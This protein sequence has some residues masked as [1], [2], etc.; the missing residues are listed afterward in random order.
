VQSGY[1]L[2]VRV[3]GLEDP[4]KQGIQKLVDISQGKSNLVENKQNGDG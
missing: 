4:I 1:L 3:S 2:E